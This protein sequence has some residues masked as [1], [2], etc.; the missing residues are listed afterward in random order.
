MIETRRAA[1]L[2]RILE[3]LLRDRGDAFLQSDPLEWVRSYRDPGDQEVAAFTASCFAIGRVDLVRKAVREV[4]DRMGPSPR[5]FVI[6]SD[7]RRFQTTYLDF[8]YRFFRG[9][10]VALLLSGLRRVLKSHGSLERFFIEG[11]DPNVSDIGPALSRFVHGFLRLPSCTKSAP[12]KSGLAAFLSNPQNGSGCK[13][14]NLFLRWVVRRGEPD[15]GLWT[16]VS[17]SKLIVPLDTHVIRMGRLLGLTQRTAPGWKMALDITRSLRRFDPDDP[18]KYDFALCH[19]GMMLA[20]PSDDNK[21]ACSPC[22]F[23]ICCTAWERTAPLRTKGNKARS[24]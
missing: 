12:L 19:A 2:K 1:A 22:M 24:V 3:A 10:D 14:L 9:N 23:R 18:V 8:V 7:L 11:Y 5:R 16:S 4:L 21:Q 17:P 6:E 15:L 13:R 20:C